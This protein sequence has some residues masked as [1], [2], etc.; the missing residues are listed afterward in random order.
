MK[1]PLPAAGRDWL[2]QLSER[3]DRL[4][5]TLLRP[6]G[7][8]LW[9]QMKLNAERASHHAEGGV[10]ALA[11]HW[12]ALHAQLPGGLELHLAGHSAGAIVIGAMLGALRDAGLRVR[13]LRLL[14]PACTTR[15]ALD[16]YAAAVRDGTL[17][18]RHWHLHLLSHA[19]ELRDHVGPYRKSL[20]LLVSRAFED[21]HKT[22]LLGL[23]ASFDAR[24]A[25]STAADGMWS[26]RGVEEVAQWLD[27]WR[28]LGTD[29][30]NR[31]VLRSSTVST[32]AGR[33]AASHG[34]FDNAVDVM[35]DLLGA[36]REP[37]RPQ[38]LRIARLDG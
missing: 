21:V 24:T 4:L 29:A 14:A 3:T 11:A 12:R 38:R 2:G 15:F 36:V 9:G 26:R 25:R 22:P 8:A 20:L 33:V 23:D 18:A 5:E 30:T 1:P 31:H 37:E 19:N 10:R 17:D 32:G 35:G 16:T 34:C 28:T 13:T 7:L 27:F 6:P